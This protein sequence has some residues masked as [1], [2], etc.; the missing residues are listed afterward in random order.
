MPCV[1]KDDCLVIKQNWTCRSHSLMVNPNAVKDLE[2]G[3]QFQFKT[4][5]CSPLP[6]W[7]LAS[8]P[9]PHPQNRI[10]LHVKGL[11]HSFDMIMHKTSLNTPLLFKTCT[12][13]FCP[14][15]HIWDKAAREKWL[16][17]SWHLFHVTTRY[18]LDNSHSPHIIHYIYIH[19]N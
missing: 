5:T 6:P 10:L 4:T 13:L 15:P 18:I 7:T 16:Q 8:H 2:L 9:L 17:I 19:F 1:E 3:K 14:Q 11:L 12:A